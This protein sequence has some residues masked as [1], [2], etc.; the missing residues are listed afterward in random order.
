MLARAEA[1]ADDGSGGTIGLAIL[2]STGSVGRQTL[3]VVDAL[4]DRFRVVALAAGGNASLLREQAVKYQPDLLAIDAI[5]S[6]DLR[7]LGRVEVGPEGL[8]AAATHPDV[9][10]VVV[11]SAGH[12]AIL[13]TH[14]AI[15]AGKTIA[16]ANKET[17]VCAGELI[18]PLAAERGVEIRPVDSEHS[19]LWQSLGRSTVVEVARLILT[20]SGGPFR[21]TSAAELERV[22]AAQALAHPT[23][24][25]GGKI[26]VDSATLMNKGL[27]VIEARWLF[28]VP[29]ER[30][31][32]LVHPESIVHSLVEFVD[33]SQVAQLSLP[34]MRLPIQYALTFPDRVPSPCR[35]LSLAEVGTLRFAPPDETRFPALALAREAGRRGSTYP[36]VLSAADEAAVDAFLAGRIRF[37]EIA[38]IVHDVLDR[39][40]PGGPLGFESI[41]EADAW[42]RAEAVR[43]IGARAGS[44]A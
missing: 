32:V 19:A 14:R 2:G 12:A 11:A 18:V 28:G 20:A 6:N 7:T 34:D 27:E 13:P 42:A 37:V 40:H 33:G 3:E 36:T 25:M 17:I 1:A 24:A 5:G 31:E 8:L 4:P 21:E 22:T 10:I 29:D 23:W 16:V 15:L 30:I 35:R 44:T 39:H 43:A 41:A 9:D 26:T 38:A